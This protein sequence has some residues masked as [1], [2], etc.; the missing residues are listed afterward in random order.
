MDALD[1]EEQLRRLRLHE[2]DWLRTLFDAEINHE[3]AVELGEGDMLKRAKEQEVR[4]EKAL[5]VVRAK[6]EA[7]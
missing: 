3:V 6:I 7:M 4:A 2:K 5:Q 1:R